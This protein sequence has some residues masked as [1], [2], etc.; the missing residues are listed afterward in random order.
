[1]GHGGGEKQKWKGWAGE[2][3]VWRAGDAERERR[4]AEK[5]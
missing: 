4:M 3:D 5:H 1:M 2:G